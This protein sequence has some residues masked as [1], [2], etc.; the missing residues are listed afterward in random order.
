[1]D[2]GLNIPATSPEELLQTQL[3]R[4]GGSSEDAPLS[5]RNLVILPDPTIESV[6]PIKASELA[7]LAAAQPPVNFAGDISTVSLRTSHHAIARDIA[8][9]HELVDVSRLY[10]IHMATLRLLLEAPAFVELVQSYSDKQ[11]A[12]VVFDLRTKIESLA[13]DSMDVLRE[14][15][16]TRPDKFSTGQVMALAGDML[17]RAGHSKVHKS[18]NLSGGL[19]AT[20]LKRIKS[21]EPVLGHP[22]QA[23]LQGK[24]EQE[25]S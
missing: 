14:R 9:G 1:M 12:E 18:V 6:R 15:L 20:A 7:E 8:G 23:A 4:N 22:A 24:A 11:P 3:E 13:H 17:D 16:D 21:G 2:S 19:D 5:L 10:G 25:G